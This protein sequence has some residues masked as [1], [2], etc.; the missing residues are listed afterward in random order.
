MTEFC[1][2]IRGAFERNGE[3]REGDHEDDGSFLPD[4]QSFD[5]LSTDQS[6]PIIDLSPPPPTPNKQAV[7][8]KISTVEPPVRGNSKSQVRSRV[9]D[10]SND[11]RRRL[12]ETNVTVPET[13]E[14]PEDSPTQTFTV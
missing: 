5:R 12:L 3:K 11:S 2:E 13:P 8:H 1:Q 9:S 4:L 10:V 7:S 6:I 14:S